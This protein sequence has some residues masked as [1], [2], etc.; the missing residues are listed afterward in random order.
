MSDRMHCQAF[1]SYTPTLPTFDSLLIFLVFVFHAILFA[2]SVHRYIH[3]FFRTI[4]PTSSSRLKIQAMN[5]FFIH[6]ILD[7]M[8][9]L[10]E[11][12]CY[13]VRSR[14]TDFN[15]Y[16]FITAQRLGHLHDIVWVKTRTSMY[17]LSNR[18]PT[19]IAGDGE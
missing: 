12:C 14:S 7:W 3:N 19:T 5:T 8:L 11:H 13:R 2:D 15:Y 10:A 9:Q 17:F 4:I 1:V 6:I 16:L 18:I